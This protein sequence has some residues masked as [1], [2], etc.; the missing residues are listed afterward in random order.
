MIY[1]SHPALIAALIIVLAGV[2]VCH[3]PFCPDCSPFCVE[4]P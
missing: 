1:R 2:A 4:T 3:P